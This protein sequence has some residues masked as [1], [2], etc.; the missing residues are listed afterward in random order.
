MIEFDGYI[1]GAAEKR[2]FA[3]SISLLQNIFLF[4]VFVFLPTV[5][6]FSKQNGSWIWIAG[7]CSLFALIPLLVRIPRSKKEKRAMTPKRIYVED[8]HVVCVAEQYVESRLIS[9]AKKVIDYGEFYEL[10]FPF[11]KISDKFIC[12]KCLLTKGTLEEFEQLFS[13]KIAKYKAN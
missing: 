1:F 9:D 11:G 10:V 5:I 12:Q 6:R 7:Y 2:F 4:A 13:G 8:D 3:K